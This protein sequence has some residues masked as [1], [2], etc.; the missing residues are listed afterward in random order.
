MKNLEKIL[1]IEDIKKTISNLIIEL[2]EI[3]YKINNVTNVNDAIQILKD[4]KFDILLLDWRLPI[5]EGN[6]VAENAG[7]KY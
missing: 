1:I 2:E 5:R 7:K 6:G 3:G 4:E